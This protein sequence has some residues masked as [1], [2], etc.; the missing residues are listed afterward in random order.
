MADSVAH[1]VAQF[2][3]QTIDDTLSSSHID[4]ILGKFVYPC[5][6]CV[7]F[8]HLITVDMDI[9]EEI[10]IE[11]SLNLR[12]VLSGSWDVDPSYFFLHH[13]GFCN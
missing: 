3:L 5:F 8:K 12:Y 9:M 10:D 11:C 13:V 7:L 6:F 1:A 4:R 2:S